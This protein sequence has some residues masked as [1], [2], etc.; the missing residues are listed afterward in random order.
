MKK[1]MIMSNTLY[2]GGAEKVLQTL[3]NNLDRSLY[4][5]TVYSLNREKIDPEIFTKPFNYKVVF[6]NPAGG[7]SLLRKVKGK[8]FNDFPPDVFYSIYIKEKYDV[9]IA[10]I[11]GESTKIISG[12][13]NIKSKKIA[14]VHTDLIKNNWTDFLYKSVDEEAEAYRKFDSIVCVSEQVKKSFEEKYSVYGSVVKYNPVDSGEIKQKALEK[15]GI[16]HNGPL[17]VSVGRLEEPKGYIRLVECA[18]KLCG[19]GEKFTLWIIGD[20]KQRPDLEKII[21]EKNLSDCVKLLGFSKNPYKYLNLADAFICSS[22][23][24]GFSTAA[25]ESIIL[26]KPVY[27]LDCPGMRELFG[28]EECGEILPNTDGDLYTLLKDAV[29]DKE[30]LKLFTDGAKRRAEFFDVKKR[31]ADIENLL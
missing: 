31:I 18:A 10:F 1:I 20:G 2:S 9:E 30:K 5:I 15:V 29:T 24:E 19:E 11:E 7:K 6:E 3:L 4:D 16:D 27:T 8:I 26:G 13:G 25:T 14:W 21:E 23:V 22:Y 28:G 17:L 12:S